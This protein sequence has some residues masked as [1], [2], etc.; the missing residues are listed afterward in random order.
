MSAVIRKMRK[1]LIFCAKNF[2]K[3]MIKSHNKFYVSGTKKSK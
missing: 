2:E 3:V 1:N